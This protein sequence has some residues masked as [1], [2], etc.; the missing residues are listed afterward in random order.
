MQVGV[1]GYAPYA[2]AK[3]GLRGLAECLQ[4]EL[5]PANIRVSLAFPPD[6]MTPGYVEG[7]LPPCCMHLTWTD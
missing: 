1:Y 5:L 2:A 7:P 6:T 3:F 4:Q